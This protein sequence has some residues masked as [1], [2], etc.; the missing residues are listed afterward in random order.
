MNSIKHGAVRVKYKMWMFCNTVLN[1]TAVRVNYN[2][3]RR[4]SI[5]GNAVQLQYEMK[6][7]ARKL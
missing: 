4:R 7:C 2:M 5:K 3:K 6:R 1:A